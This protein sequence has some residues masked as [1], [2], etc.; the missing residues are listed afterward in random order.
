MVKSRQ[1]VNR[2]CSASTS[3]QDI[4]DKLLGAMTASYVELTAIVSGDAYSGN[5]AFSSSVA[6]GGRPIVNPVR[7]ELT[8][9][10]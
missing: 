10:A 7:I 1:S 4:Y 6:S 2:R 3:L 5:G 9:S 8:T